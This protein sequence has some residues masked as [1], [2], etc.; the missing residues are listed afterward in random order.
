M[1]AHVL[2]VL[3]LFGAAGCY[4]SHGAADPPDPRGCDPGTPL[5]PTELLVGY[6]VGTTSADGAARRARAPEAY[7][8]R[9]V[10]V[11]LR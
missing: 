3:A 8:P 1:R 11:P 2:A 6:S 10:R 9:I 7:W 5:R 4:A